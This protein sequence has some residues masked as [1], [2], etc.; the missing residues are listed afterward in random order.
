MLLFAQQFLLSTERK[1]K[2]SSWAPFL[3]PI[4]HGQSG[5]KSA[6]TDM[7]EGRT[8]RQKGGSDHKEPSSIPRE[9]ERSLRD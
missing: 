4:Q 9:R 6:K 8:P 2:E 5:N 3:V 7:G 1:H